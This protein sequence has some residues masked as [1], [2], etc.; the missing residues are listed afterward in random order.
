M[1]RPIALW[2]KLEFTLQKISPARKLSI[3]EENWFQGHQSKLTRFFFL[4]FAVDHITVSCAFCM[5]PF[6]KSPSF[7]LPPPWTQKFGNHFLL[8]LQP[9]LVCF[10]YAYIQLVLNYKIKVLYLKLHHNFNYFLCIGL[11]NSIFIQPK[12]SSSRS[13]TTKTSTSKTS[14]G[15]I[16]DWQ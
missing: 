12:R 7:P 15:K 3:K 8:K 4:L 11:L 10:T 14:N 6:K 5:G 9:N 13:S 2:N 16:I 1:L